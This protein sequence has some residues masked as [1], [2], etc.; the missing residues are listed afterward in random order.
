MRI[1]PLESN[2]SRHLYDVRQE[3]RDEEI[4][5]TASNHPRH[6]LGSALNE[7]DI[8]RHAATPGRARST[9][10][11]CSGKHERHR[12]RVV[13]PPG[14]SMTVAYHDSVPHQRP[15]PMPIRHSA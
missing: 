11:S 4:A 5:E 6:V 1:E 2:P 3:G 10:R 14:G 15:P 12:T 7:C 9:C 13:R 8:R